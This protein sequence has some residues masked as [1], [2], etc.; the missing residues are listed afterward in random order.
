MHLQNTLFWAIAIT[1]ST[2]AVTALV[3]P[4]PSAIKIPIFRKGSR[5]AKRDGSIIET[6]TDSAYYYSE[7]SIGTPPQ[8]FVV[9]LDTGSADL[10]VT[11][12]SCKSSSCPTHGFNESLSSSYVPIEN[13][14]SVLK[15]GTPPTY[16]YANGSYAYET[17]SFGNITVE[18]QKFALMHNI[19][20]NMLNALMPDEPDIS[21]ILGLGFPN[22]TNSRKQAYNPLVTNM[23]EQRLIPEP[24]FSWA[25]GTGFAVP[26]DKGEMVLGAID[27]TKHTGDIQYVPVVPF[28]ST[29]GYTH[30]Q[31]YSQFLAVADNGTEQVHTSLLNG[32]SYPL[33]IFDTGAPFTEL[34]LEY[35][36]AIFTGLTGSNNFTAVAPDSPLWDIDCSYLNTTKRIQL[37]LSH[38]LDGIA[39]D[40]SPLILDMPASEM[41]I[42]L[43]SLSGKRATKCAWGIRANKDLHFLLIGQTFLHN[44]YLVFDIGKA[45]TGFAPLVGTT[46]KVSV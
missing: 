13:D 21:G 32:T 28:S 16:N 40:S 11:S 12:A 3:L 7:I 25:Y 39:K 27:S 34:P 33:A 18:H 43:D 8:K 31:S 1:A 46:T 4:S 45:Q 42:P 44:M 23:A 22:G 17:V 10:W 15:Y 41:I 9:T 30:W 19:S 24:I 5:L 2:T 29:L 14:T 26:G 6:I 36:Q 20:A 35:A 37:G 38:S